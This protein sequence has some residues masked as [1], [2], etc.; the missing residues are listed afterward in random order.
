MKN[1]NK[2]K[3]IWFFF[4]HK[5]YNR[6]ADSNIKHVRTSSGFTVLWEIKTLHFSYLF[7]NDDLMQ[8]DGFHS[9]DSHQCFF[10]LRR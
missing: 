3:V 1:T 10:L 7:P 8:P 5:L 4:V 2:S 9:Y 6:S